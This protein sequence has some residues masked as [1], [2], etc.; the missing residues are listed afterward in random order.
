M[1]ERKKDEQAVTFIIIDLF[2]FPH[3][4][5]RSW[6]HPP[7]RQ[8]KDPTCPSLNP[9]SALFSHLAELSE[10]FQQRFA[11]LV[12]GSLWQRLLPSWLAEQSFS[13]SLV[14]IYCH[15]RKTQ[16]HVLPLKYF[17]S[18]RPLVI[19]ARVLALAWKSLEIDINFQI[20]L[21]I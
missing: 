3:Q 6:L 13:P 4:V 15:S 7:C 1:E 2:L 16:K 12:S 5:M 19:S 20:Q 21:K 10:P 8:V 17:P 11:L 14:M 18:P 9:F